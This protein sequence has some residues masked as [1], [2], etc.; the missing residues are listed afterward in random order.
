MKNEMRNQELHGK[1]LTLTGTDSDWE[2]WGSKDPYYAVLSAPKFRMA[3]L[4]NSALNEFFSSGSEHVNH[5]FS[6]LRKN[7]RSDFRPRRSL[8]FGCG[9]GR[10]AVPLATYSESVTAVDISPAML[11]EATRNAVSQGAENIEFLQT[12]ELDSVGSGTL[13]FVHSYIVFQHIPPNRGKILFR[14]L[15]RKLRPRG[16]GAL[17]LTIARNAPLRKRLI[18]SV[19]RRSTIANQVA[20]LFQG[21]PASGPAIYMFMYS[22][23]DIIFSMQAEGCGRIFTEFTQH[24][25]Y[26]G[27]MLY[28]EKT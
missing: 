20:N 3:S 16:L 13:D 5:V 2:E 24:T 6:V 23:S 19:R 18:A 1:T 26:L 8:D 10:I 7:F 21:R 25:D 12:R 28:F 14:E 15:L 9:V 27:A 22:L 4:D 17:H 11:Q